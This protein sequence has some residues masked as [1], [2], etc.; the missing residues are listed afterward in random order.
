MTSIFNNKETRKWMMQVL[1]VLLL[2]CLM[3]WM[4][5]LYYNYQLKQIHIEM[6]G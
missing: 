3:A 6:G 4:A 5:W 1:I 2:F